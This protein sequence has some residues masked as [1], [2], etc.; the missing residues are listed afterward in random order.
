MRASNSV[1]AIIR[2]IPNEGHLEERG[3]LILMTKKLILVAVAL[4]VATTAIVLIVR[5]K[6]G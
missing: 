5:A 2:V 1:A 3:K 6:H 4:A